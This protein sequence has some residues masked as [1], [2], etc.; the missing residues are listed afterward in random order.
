MDENIYFLCRAAVVNSNELLSLR[1]GNINIRNERLL[2]RQ[3]VKFRMTIH[4]V[5]C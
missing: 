3:L 5:M 4:I 1:F 2:A